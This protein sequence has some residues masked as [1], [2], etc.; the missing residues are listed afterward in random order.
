M[1]EVKNKT[2]FKLKSSKSGQGL[3]ENENG[4]ENEIY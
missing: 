4:V 1:P 2:F 3:Q